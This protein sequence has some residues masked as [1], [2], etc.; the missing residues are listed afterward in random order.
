MKKIYTWLAQPA[1]RNL[2]VADLRKLKGK[3]KFTQVRT[4]TLDEA[5]AAEKAGIDMIIA[6]AKNI[7]QVRKGSQNLFLTASLFWEE[8]IKKEEILRGAF[9][10]LEE[11]AD[12]VFTPRNNEIIEMLAMEDIPVMG[13]LGLVPRKTTWYGGLRAIGKD[14]KE[15]FELFKKFKDL[16]NA[17]AFAAEGELIP[18][19]VMHE[20]SK[21]TKLITISMGSGN[22][23]DVNYLF[24]EDICGDNPNP[25]RHAKSY[26]NLL[27][28]RDQIKNER[29]NALKAF[30]KDSNEGIFPGKEQSVF[31]DEEN[32]K[33]F[34]K[35]IR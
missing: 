18:E 8:F 32:F 26:G 11:G 21:K 16:E 31:M 19:N 23:A 24:M 12:A 2:T 13:H 28:L 5:Y 6:N 29:L 15:A 33:E 9:K 10:A 3:K 30:K 35:L 1:Q 27:K 14:S 34:I 22:K 20:I 7:P 25:P 17:G 4:N